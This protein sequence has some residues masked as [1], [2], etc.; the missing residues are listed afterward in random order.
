MRSPKNGRSFAF[1]RPWTS[2]WKRAD[3]PG[4]F[5][6]S[7]L[8][9]LSTKR[10]VCSPPGSGQSRANSLSIK[11]SGA[12]RSKTWS[13]SGNRNRSRSSNTHSKRPFHKISLLCPIRSHRTK[14]TNSAVRMRFTNECLKGKCKWV[15]KY[16]RDCIKIRKE[17]NR[18]K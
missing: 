18:K 12:F 3:P 11:L 8:T 14:H 4:F 2:K 10:T 1:V 16:L 15:G 6:N 5:F 13:A 9:S 17:E 7:T